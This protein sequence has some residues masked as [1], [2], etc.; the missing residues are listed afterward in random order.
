MN[1]HLVDD[2]KVINRM[3]S[4]FEEALPGQNIFVC[5]KK[6][7]DLVHVNP[8]NHNLYLYRLTD[9]LDSFCTNDVHRVIFHCLTLEKIRFFKRFI[10]HKVLTYWIVW[11][12]DLYNELLATR[13]YP[14]YY[15]KKYLSRGRRLN[16][17]LGNLG[18]HTSESKTILSFVR[19]TIDFI[20]GSD[21]PIMVSYLKSY[22]RAK[23]LTGFFYYPIDQVL[24][25][26]V[27]EFSQGK[28]VMLGNSASI[29][30][31]HLYAF[32]ILSKLN[33]GERKI[34][35]PLNYNGNEMY[36]KHVVDSGYKMFDCK[37][38][39]LTKFLPLDE[40]NKLLL[41]SGYC[42]YASW[43]QEAMGN[44]LI[45]LYL[46]CKVFISNKS[47]LFALFKQM[48]IYVYELETISE[49]SFV[50]LLPKEIEVNRSLLISIYSKNK[51]I[52]NIRDLF[53]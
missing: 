19:D 8:Q 9:E 16:L 47:P 42:I 50:P 15:E 34:I 12:G 23:R 40:Y 20:V 29:T 33:L 7:G 51:Q 49:E 5:F 10:N 35:V 6:D 22:I 45:A 14:I 30:N 26:L 44:I 2:E 11:G 21:Y 28:D 41:S 36:K 25:S 53:S 52:D 17:L 18:I 4:S 39:P 13:G 43:R 31:N 27:T 1:L 32:E 37:F 24:G 3:I 48:G 46:G 38:S